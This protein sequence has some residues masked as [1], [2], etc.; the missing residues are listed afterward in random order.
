MILYSILLENKV[1][2]NEFFKEHPFDA[3]NQFVNLDYILNLTKL[4]E[5]RNRAL[6]GNSSIGNLFNIG[7]SGIK[8]V[9]DIRVSNRGV[10]RGGGGGGR[11]TMAPHKIWTRGEKGPHFLASFG[12]SAINQYFLVKLFPHIVNLPAHSNFSMRLQT[13]ITTNCSEKNK[14]L[15]LSMIFRN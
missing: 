11:G 9:S 6:N 3:K 13:V 2:H 12:L 5:R 15:K 4:A 8:L 1:K 7:R 10:G 14:L